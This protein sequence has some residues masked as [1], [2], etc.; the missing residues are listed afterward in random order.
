MMTKNMKKTIAVMTALTMAVGMMVGCGQ[1]EA[2]KENKSKVKTEVQKKP[3]VKE[4][5]LAEFLTG[6]DDHY[7]LQGAEGVDY[8]YGIVYDK[9]VVKEVKAETQNVNLEK[10]GTYKVTYK[11]TVDTDAMKDYKKAEAEEAETKPADKTDDS[12]TEVEI[13]KEVE[14]VDKDKAQD[15]ADK[16]EVVWGDSNMS[17]PKSDGTEV[18]EEVKTPESTAKDPDKAQTTTK[19]QDQ[20]ASKPQSNTTKPT[21][22]TQKPAESKPSKPAHT[23]SWTPVTTTKQE[24]VVDSAAWDE[25]IYEYRTICT[26]GA[27]LTNADIGAHYV[28][29][30]GG[31]SNKRVQTGTKHHDATGHYETKTITTGYK[32]SCGATK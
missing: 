32:C 1:K 14:V 29:C 11:V 18:Q 8:T 31:Y 20:Q 30:D 26:C 24:W 19:P 13:E 5:D 4:A 3:E 25:P 28:D 9:S 10:L 22:N 23:H 2:K 15:L 27:D 12:L 17:V 6:L 16:G 21:Q 7:V